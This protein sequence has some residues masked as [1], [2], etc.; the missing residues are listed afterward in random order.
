MMEVRELRWWEEY[1]IY[2]S[3]YFLAG[4]FAYILVEVVNG[5][6]VPSKVEVEVIDR[7]KE[8]AKIEGE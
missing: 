8:E 4:L 1:L 2:F 5:I 7:T 3:F 6:G